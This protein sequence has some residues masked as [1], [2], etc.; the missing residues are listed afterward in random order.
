MLRKA[1]HTTGNDPV[2]AFNDGRK[3]F[4]P[5]LSKGD[6]RQA[7]GFNADWRALYH[8]RRHIRANDVPGRTAFLP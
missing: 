7:R 1:D 2:N 8:F 4:D 5:A 6:V 3:F